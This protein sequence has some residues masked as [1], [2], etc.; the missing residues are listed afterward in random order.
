ME[1]INELILAG[2]VPSQHTYWLLSFSW[3]CVIVLCDCQHGHRNATA[4]FAERIW[5]FWFQIPEDGWR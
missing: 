4:I 5:D 1:H 2:I 3:M